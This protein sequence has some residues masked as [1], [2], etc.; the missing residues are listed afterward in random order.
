MRIVFLGPPGSGKGTQAS[1]YCRARDCRHISTGELLREAVDAGTSLGRDARTYMDSGDLVPD[2]VILGLIEA[3][4]EN[5]K[6]PVLFDGFPRNLA[7]ARDLDMLLDGRGERVDA[8]VYLNVDEQEL[9]RRLLSR[10]RSDDTLETVLNRLKVYK[11]NTL[12]L[13]DYYLGHGVLHEV[14][15]VGEIAAIQVRVADA[16]G[17]N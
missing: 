12:P 13:I 10:G 14:D 17:G 11:E 2:A 1:V 9:I 3:T 4:L 5:E 8:A 6:R 16:I 7:Q 15:G